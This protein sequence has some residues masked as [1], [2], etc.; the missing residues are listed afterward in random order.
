METEAERR[1]AAARKD[2]KDEKS[3]AELVET[4]EL[5]CRCVYFESAVCCLVCLQ[6]GQKRRMHC[7]PWQNDIAW[8][9]L[10]APTSGALQWILRLGTRLSTE[11]TFHTF[12]Y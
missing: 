6:S 4:V 8:F 9:M 10:Q 2:G 5:I 7:V 1:R 12:P 11:S 3:G